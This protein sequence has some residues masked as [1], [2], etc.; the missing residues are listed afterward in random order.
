LKASHEGKSK[1]FATL[2][3]SEFANRFS[4]WRCF[5]NLGNGGRSF[6]YMRYCFIFMMY[7][8]L[9]QKHTKKQIS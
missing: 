6:I 9:Q 2:S 1:R 5:P 3:V 4:E 7:C 8:W